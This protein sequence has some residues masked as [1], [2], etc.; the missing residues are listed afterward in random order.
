MVTRLHGVDVSGYQAGYV[1]V[2]GDAFLFV[3]ATEG[4]TFTSSSAAA[5]AARGRA[6]GQVV[7]FYHFMWPGNPE[8]QAVYFVQQ[9]KPQPGD[10]LVC[11][12][13]KAGTSNADKDTFIRK[14][15]ELAPQCRVGLY[16]N[17]SWWLTVDTTGYFG[18]FLWIADYRGKEPPIKAAWTFWQYT[19][20]PL[21]QNWCRFTSRADLVTW[22]RGLIPAPPKPPTPPVPP[23]PP[24]PAVRKLLNINCQ[25]PGFAS[26]KSALP[27]SRRCAMLADAV[28]KSGASI[29]TAQEL[30]KAE[31]A[32]LARLLPGWKYQRADGGGR[33]LNCVL[34]KASE[35]TL[36]GT[37]DQDLDSFGQLQRTLLA[38]M[39]V[40]RDRSYVWAGSTHLA[41]A[42][43]DLTA[44]AAVRARTAQAQQ[45]GRRLA[46]SKTTI[47]GGDWNSS[48]PQT[49]ASSVRGILHAA[50]FTFRAPLRDSKH[51]G[52]DGVGAKA[53]VTILAETVHPLGRAS[54]HDGRLVTFTT[55]RG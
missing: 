45:I 41:A 53:N 9:A 5:Q 44:S 22:A 26:T 3:K 31:A 4:R 12:W 7:G 51:N 49:T 13:E 17:T 33:G 15:K 2:P 30:G 32:D 55:K 39:L 25:W 8:E 52:I 43:S 38:V 6:A 47:L 35:W 37:L 16:C 19:D 29:V 1:P 50:G 36:R 24:A 54:D 23:K 27:W 28:L 11:D 46:G 48:Y 10:L 20:K 42:A 18:D 14:V 21:D 34:W 40:H